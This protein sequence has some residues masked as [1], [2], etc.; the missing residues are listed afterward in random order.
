MKGKIFI[1]GFMLLI[2]ML[3]IGRVEAAVIH[4]YD[5]ND[6]QAAI[7][8]VPD[9]STVYVHPGT[10][11]PIDIDGR[12]RLNIIGYPGAT[13]DGYG[14]G[15]DCVYINNSSRILIKG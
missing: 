7:D 4:V 11:D 13:I 15:D 3:F 12:T 1:I 14:F 2:S 8:S 6:L 10:Y 5:G 9:N